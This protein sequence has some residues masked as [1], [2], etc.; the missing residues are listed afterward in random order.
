[1]MIVKTKDDIKPDSTIS[2]TFDEVKRDMNE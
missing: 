2:H 1:M